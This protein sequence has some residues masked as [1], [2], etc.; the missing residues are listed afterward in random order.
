MAVHAVLGGLL[1]KFGALGTAGKAVAVTAVAAAGFAATGAAVVLPEP[2]QAP[3]DRAVQTVVTRQEPVEA[4]E[5][6]G[7]T[8]TP[9]PA[10]TPTP[11]PSAEPTHDNFGA[12]VSEDAKDGG[13]DGRQISQDA[14]ANGKGKANGKSGETGTGGHGSPKSEN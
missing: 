13:V 8:D 6:A 9:D 12:R 1:A 3:A 11:T 5:P 7:T 4:G 14:K 10:P 2:V